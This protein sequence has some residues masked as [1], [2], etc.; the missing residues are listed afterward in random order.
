MSHCKEVLEEIQDIKCLSE[1]LG[2]YFRRLEKVVNLPKHSWLQKLILV[3]SDMAMKGIAVLKK[4]MQHIKTISMK[5][6]SKCD[7]Q[8]KSSLTPRN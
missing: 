1:A 7:V 6:Q 3:A 4:V 8:Q 5:R 2:R